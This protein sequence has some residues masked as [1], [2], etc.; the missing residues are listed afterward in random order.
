VVIYIII[1]DSK[2]LKGKIFF[3][4]KSIFA[5]EARFNPKIAIFAMNLKLC[6]TTS[7][8]LPS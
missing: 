5:E 1:G 4:E 2:C 3:A 6:S 8:C 7:L